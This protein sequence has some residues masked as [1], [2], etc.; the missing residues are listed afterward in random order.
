MKLSTDHNAY[1]VLKECRLM[2]S[3]HHP[4]IVQFIG[5]CLHS[6]TQQPIL[7]MEKLK[8]QLHQ[9]LLT[10]PTIPPILKHSIL[11][12]VARGLTYLHP[13]VIHRDLSAKNILLTPFFTAKICDFGNSLSSDLNGRLQN[14]T[15]YPGKRVYMPPEAL[16]EPCVYDCSMDIFSFGHL[17][18]FTT[19]QVYLLTIDEY[20]IYGISDS[21]LPC[22]YFLVIL[23]QA[24]LIVVIV[25]SL[26]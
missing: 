16:A 14:L 22:R 3:L 18:L 12:D 4:N 10:C 15:P 21:T 8:S 25:A 2:S 20:T 19:I 11:R 5:L 23:S 7:V 26:K 13:Q 9:L 17:V 1:D 24:V 6:S